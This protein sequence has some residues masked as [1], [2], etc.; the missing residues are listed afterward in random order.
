MSG[1]K[2][3][4]SWDAAKTGLS[5]I[6]A[7]E[8]IFLLVDAYRDAAVDRTI[9]EYNLRIQLINEEHKKALRDRVQTLNDELDTYQSRI[10]ELPLSGT[11]EIF[12]QK[13][14]FTITNMK[15]GDSGYQYFECELHYVNKKRQTFADPN[16]DIKMEGMITGGEMYMARD[17]STY[18]VRLLIAD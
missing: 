10:F 11:K 3:L 12:D 16:R 17:D 4:F 1:L 13:F 14:I 6:T 9:T 8:V 7:L 18:V 2:Q 15:T 5:V